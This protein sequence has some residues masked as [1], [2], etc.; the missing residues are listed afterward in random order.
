MQAFQKVISHF[1]KVEHPMLWGIKYE[2][3]KEA[4]KGG[5]MEGREVHGSEFKLVGKL[6]DELPNTVQKCMEHRGL[7]K[8]IR[9]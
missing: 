8:Y 9:N 5:V 4:N 2:G 6:L 3:V 1:M 7:Y